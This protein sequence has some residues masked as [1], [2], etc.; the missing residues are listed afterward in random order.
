MSVRKPIPSGTRFTRLVV[1]NSN[2]QLK[3]CGG[4]LRYYAECR[5]DCGKIK[6]INEKCLRNGGTKSCGCFT[7]DCTI[8]RST[9]H[10]YSH[11]NSYVPVYRT[12][13]DMIQRCTNPKNNGFQNYGGR[14][15]QIDP[16]WMQFLNFLKDMG[17]PE[18]GMTLERKDVNG[19][20]CKSN[21][22]WI[23][24][25]KQNQNKRSNVI[26]T[27]FGITACMNELSRQFGIANITVWQRIQNGAHPECALTKDKW[28]TQ[29]HISSCPKCQSV[30]KIP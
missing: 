30:T 14:G 18:P 28:I 8:A 7:R 9:I 2:P 23:P 12:W 26:L 5:C 27:A 13:A 24:R 11:R 17:E 25:A 22:C 21:C 16:D 6:W 4:S 29:A 10:N 3:M 20:Y 1:T 15:I 19:N